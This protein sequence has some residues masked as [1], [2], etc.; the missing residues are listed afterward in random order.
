MQDIEYIYAELH[1]L[2]EF[3]HLLVIS[4]EYRATQ[5]TELSLGEMMRV[6]EQPRVVT[7]DRSRTPLPIFEIEYYSRFV[8]FTWM[9]MYSTFHSEGISQRVVWDP[10]IEGS[11]HD[12]VVGRH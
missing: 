9:P 8:D 12:G 6:H 2:S 11:I 1:W 3:M 7:S 5:M 10:G 4:S